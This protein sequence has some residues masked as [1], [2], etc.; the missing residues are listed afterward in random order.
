MASAT[1]SVWAIDLGSSNLKALRLR[2]VN[3]AIEVTGFDAISHGKILSGSGVSRAEANELIALS[4]RQ[5]ASRNDL[6]ADE[7][8]IS[9]PSQNSFARF[10]NL[11]PVEK[12]RIPEIVK[13]E[14][15]QQ[16]PFELSDVQ[17]DWQLMGETATGE[18]RVALF[19]IKN[20]VVTSSLEHFNRENI[21]VSFVQMVSM[22]L[23]NYLAFDRPDL[24]GSDNE[25]TIILNVGAE[26]TDLVVC[27]KSEVWQRCIPMGGNTFTK[28][29]AE[30]F[31]LNFQK[32]EKLKRTAAMSKYARQILQAMK[33]VFTDLASEIQRSIGFYNSSNPN[34]KL[35]RIVA[36]G[37]GTKMRGLLKYLQQTLQIPIERPDSFS[38][39][40]INPDVSAAKFHDSVCDFGVVYGLGLQAL[41]YHKVESNLL[42]ANIAR[43]MAWTGK[44]K[45]FNMAACLLLVVAILG[46][47]R[48]SIDK[49]NYGK[50]QPLRRQIGSIINKAEQNIAKVKE[51]QSKGDSFETIIQKAYE[52]FK[53]RDIVPKV[54]RTVLAALPNE[55]NN[56]AQAELYRA[57]A[58]GDIETVMK[59]D[60]KERKQLFVTGMSIYFAKDVETAVFADI[61]A[62][63]RT[64]RETKGSFGGGMGY[65]GGGGGMG[66]GGGGGGMGYGGGGG[67][68]G[69]VSQA[70]YGKKSY[71]KSKYDYEDEDEQQ[72]EQP[73]QSGAG[74]IVR[75]SGYSPYKNIQEL[76]DPVGVRDDRSKW[77]LVTRLLHLDE[78][79]DGNSPFELYKKTDITH[80]RLEFGEVEAGDETSK[81]LA[82]TE[83]EEKKD[84]G[85]SDKDKPALIDPM[86]GEV[87]SKVAEL[88]NYG[89]KKIDRLGKVVY[90]V[91]D[92]WFKLDFKLVWKDAP[93]IAGEDG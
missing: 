10:V 19:A 23:Y 11:P 32:A 16:I 67:G 33:P 75:I 68:F 9:V 42:P 54:F 40:L 62:R 39:L 83:V 49:I 14:A 58:A 63:A 36:L 46:F 31:K 66:Y 61:S 5:F 65:G 37:G 24:V 77:G 21:A 41:G 87:I 86:T 38:K 7:V 3:S 89:N 8:I 80:F 43:S 2:E 52:P 27:T 50:K 30:T 6:G 73:E 29:I 28:A 56:P 13:F 70:K 51:Q 12:K 57:F 78:V 88:D 64:G 15:A 79:F 25:G 76:I 74:F 45:Y 60:R 22:A 53:Y 20:D 18:S 34:I 59:T 85:G 26:N 48:V 92:H 35:S 72:E 47:V 55:K 44:V 4:L 90:Q 91:N 1:G 17:W 69:G 82:I 81:E 93:E 71:S 84:D